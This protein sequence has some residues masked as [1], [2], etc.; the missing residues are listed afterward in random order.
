M[1]VVAHSFPH[2]RRVSNKLKWS[3][4]VQVSPTT[5]SVPVGGLTQTF[6]ATQDVIL[7]MPGSTVTGQIACSGGRNVRIV[8]GRMDGSGLTE[9]GTVNSCVI[10]WDR[11]GPID[12]GQTGVQ[13]LFVE[14]VDIDLSG[15][16]DLDMFWVGGE[17][18]S[19][20]AAGVGAA[21]WNRPILYLQ[22]CRLAGALWS[23]GGHHPDV[24]QKNRP[25]AGVRIDKCTVTWSYQG[26]FLPPQE[27]TV[28][29]WQGGTPFN[30]FDRL[31]LI[32]RSDRSAYGLWMN[33]DTNGGTAFNVPAPLPNTVLGNVWIE[34]KAGDTL[35]SNLVYPRVGTGVTVDTPVNSNPGDIGMIL[36]GDSLSGTWP[37]AA[38]IQGTIRKGIPPGGDF[39]SVGVPGL[40]YS[41]PGYA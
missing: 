1:S 26:I 28:D 38:R 20:T 6:G 31:N 11:M 10:N 14:G 29:W 15:Q 13:S 5:V 37:A 23:G 25:L 24:I 41:S 2:S 32:A 4:P 35:G 19:A 27:G 33:Y 21:K 12:G 36:A 22:N 9:G 3:P 30:D 7:T 34:G 16:H 8:G 39:C 17:N 40:S 18:S